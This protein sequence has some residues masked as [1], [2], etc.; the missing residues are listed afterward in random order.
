MG[1]ARLSL[2]REEPQQ[3]DLLV[4]DAFTGHA[5]PVHLLTREAG[6][7][8][9]RHLK[10]DGVLAFNITSQFLDFQPVIQKFAE[11]FGLRSVIVQNDGDPD[12]LTMASRWMLLSRDE[13]LYHT[14]PA[15]QL[16]SPSTGKN[17]SL[18][19]DSYNDLFSILK[20]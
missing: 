8:Y 11:H 17:I 1:D 15:A 2:E 16:G 3:L 9:L 13:G 7:I 12:R 19:T 18:W 5:P 20:K 6:Q 4:M 14:I 10:P